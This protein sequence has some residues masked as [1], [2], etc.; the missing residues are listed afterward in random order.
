MRSIRVATLVAAVM[1]ALAACGGSGGGDPTAVVKE[2]FTLI[3]QGKFDEVGNLA[4]AAKKAEVEESL[5]FAAG[6][7][8]QMPPGLDSQSIID[9]MKITISGLDVK[10]ESRSGDTATVKVTGTIKIAFDE[11]KMREVMKAYLEQLGQ[12]V[13]DTVLDAAMSQMSGLLSF[14]QPLDETTTLVNEG[15]SWKICG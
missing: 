9:S 1:V 8:G 10:E 4:C 5:N 13:D 15:G 6:V 2:A 3:E 14:D 12:P 7:A 11:A